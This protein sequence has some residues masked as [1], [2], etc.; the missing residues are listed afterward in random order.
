MD[1]TLDSIRDIKIYQSL[2]GYRFSVDSL[3]LSDF[4]ALRK[5]GSIADLGAG[6]G[7]IGLLLARKYPGTAV[8]L[9]E[10]QESLAG[11]AEKNVVLNNLQNSVK[12]IKC[13]IRTLSCHDCSSRQYDLVVSNPPFRRP[14]SGL[15]NREEERAIARHEIKLRLHELVGASVRLLRPKGRFCFIHHPD[16]LAEIMDTLR[17][18]ALEPKRMRFVHSSFSSGA[19]MVLL[20]AVREGRSGLKI[21]KPFYIYNNN[22]SYTDEMHLIY[23]SP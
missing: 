22:G 16:R 5:V 23:N 2:T 8:T 17:K 11:L 3:L 15:T 12:V 19:K 1:V 4:V 13:D 18:G 14:K 10:V 20:E 6:T 21:E 9:F 7:I